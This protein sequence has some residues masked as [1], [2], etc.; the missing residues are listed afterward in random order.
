MDTLG[1]QGENVLDDPFL[2]RLDLH[3]QLDARPLRMSLQMAMAQERAPLH[4]RSLQN[5]SIVVHL[6]ELSPDEVL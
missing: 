1:D 2:F 5:D 6:S 3:P 4:H